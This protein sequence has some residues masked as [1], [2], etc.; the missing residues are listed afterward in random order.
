[1]RNRK[2]HGVGKYRLTILI[3]S[4]HIH[5]D[6]GALAFPP[7]IDSADHLLDHK[8]P[9]NSYGLVQYQLVV[10]VQ[11]SVR[12]QSRDH[13][14]WH[15]WLGII[16]IHPKCPGTGDYTKCGDCFQPLLIDIVQFILPGSHTQ[17][18]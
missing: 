2:G 15:L 7:V 17:I 9:L 6:L 16:G 13:P 8:C 1:M 4:D 3:P 10:H 12:A 5:L 14:G 11:G 18:I